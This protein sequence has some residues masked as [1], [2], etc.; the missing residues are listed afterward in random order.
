MT[1]EQQFESFM[2]RYQNM[3]FSTALRLVANQAEAED[4]AQEVFLKAYERFAELRQSPT[5][6]G[7]LKKVA[8]N[9]SLNHL[10]RYRSRWSFFSELFD[11][12][13]GNWKTEADIA[14][15][16]DLGEEMS[17]ADQ[18][19]QVEQEL[20]KLPATQR[21]P[22]VLFHMEGLH[23]EEIAAKLKISLGL[24]KT[25]IF[26]GRESLRK[27]LQCRLGST[28][29][30]IPPMLHGNKVPAVRFSTLEGAFP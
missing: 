22:L 13:G 28:T 15:P 19:R 9:L 25:N 3:V 24:V 23:Y 8:T 1:D 17:Q 26:R 21:V 4:I 5:V 7:W 29:L 12:H 16:G 6:K 14:A 30:A 2:R 27:N 11:N 10:S 18:R 20:R